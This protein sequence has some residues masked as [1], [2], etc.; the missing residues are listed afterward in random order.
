MSNT[1]VDDKNPET[2]FILQQNYPNPFN[3]CTTIKYTI[4]NVTLSGVEGS[5]VQLKVYDVLGKEVAT[6]VNE[7]KPAGSYEVDFNAA[8]LSSG[9]Y[10]YK[11]TAGS[12]VETKKMTLLR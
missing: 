3:P 6:L 4:P 11:L 7:E 12:F 5:R 1:A 2:D 10:F 8:G 9:I